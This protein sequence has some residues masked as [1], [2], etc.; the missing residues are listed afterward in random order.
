MPTTSPNMA[1]VVPTPSTGA[2]GTGDPGPGYAANISSDLSTLIDAHDHSFGK[3][4]P[5][6]QAGLSINGD[7]PLAS[8]NLTQIRAARFTSQA[9][10]L[11]LAGDAGE[12]YVKNGDLW[13]V[14]GT[15]TQV[16][17]TA[18]SA[19]GTGVQG[20]TGAA[21]TSFVSNYFQAGVTGVTGA[22]FD[23]SS[24]CAPVTWNQPWLVAGTLSQP[25][26]LGTGA[27]SIVAGT[28]GLY[29]V[30]YRL[31]FTGVY[32]NS[33]NATVAFVT[34]NA[35][36]INAS[37]SLT[38]GTFIPQSAA[39]ADPRFIASGMLPLQTT[40]LVLLGAGAILTVWVRTPAGFN[41]L[42]CL[43]PTGT[44]ISVKQIG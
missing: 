27:A 37:N 8:N 5:V 4:V 18:G 30:S 3:G 6:S 41:G 2:S 40:F 35:T 38:G 22:A 11:N 34:I 33:S 24:R 19:L 16:Q 32:G 14:S 17:V 21:G 43:Q 28:A 31:G 42:A 23:T 20:P 44:S 7:L 13:Y 12:V 36:G 15:G 26:S 39:G 9:S 1:L 10:A 29:E 25:T